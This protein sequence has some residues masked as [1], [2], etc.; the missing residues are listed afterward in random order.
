MLA[1]PDYTL[2]VKVTATLISNEHSTKIHST[3]SNFDSMWEVQCSHTSA[4]Q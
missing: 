3:G 1:V 4:C 2:A